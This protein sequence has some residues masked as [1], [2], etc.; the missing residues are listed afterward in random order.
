MGKLHQKVIRVLRQH[1]GD[2]T[3]ALDEVEETGQLTGVVISKAFK[4]LDHKKR[5]NLLWQALGEGLTLP[6]QS[7]VGPIATLTP[8]E[9]N[10]RA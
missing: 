2:V 1:L 10:V 7:H 4:K 3:D 6:E 5:Q 8:A 9:A